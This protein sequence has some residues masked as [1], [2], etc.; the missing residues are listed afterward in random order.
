MQVIAIA[1]IHK[2]I[3]SCSAPAVLPTLVLGL[4]LSL[5]VSAQDGMEEMEEIEELIVTGSLIKG[6]PEDAPNPVTT[7]SRDDWFEQGSPTIV[8]LIKNLG[9]SSGVD[10]ETNQFTS[11]GL[12]GAANVNLRGLGPG[13]TLTLL[14]G[15]RL[16][17]SGS[18]VIQAGYQQFVDINLIPAIALGGVDFLREGASA[19][20]GSDAVAGVAN[21][22]T[23]GDLDG[24][25]VLINHRI[26]Q[27]SQGWTESGIA[28]GHQFDHGGHLLL[29]AGYNK[30]SELQIRDRP[31]ALRS[32]DDNPEGGWSGLG[33]PS[34]YV[35]VSGAGGGRTFL[36]PACVGF[37]GGIFGGTCRFQYTQY[38]NIIEN[39]ERWQAY[40]EYEYMFANDSK[41]TLSALYAQTNVPDWKTSPS[42]PPA[43]SFLSNI[44][45][46]NHPG[47]VQLVNDVNAGNYAV[48]GGQCSVEFTDGAGGP[49]SGNVWVDPNAAGNC[50]DAA[51]GMAG[52]EKVTQAGF[53]VVDGRVVALS[54]A[55][56][57]DGSVTTTQT[58]N[59]GNL[60]FIG[61]ILGYG[62]LE[63]AD[64]ERKRNQYLLTAD[65]DFSF[66]GVDAKIT[67]S[68]GRQQNKILGADVLG[69]RLTWAMGGLGG[70]ECSP[71]SDPTTNSAAVAGVGNCRYYNPFS[72]ALQRSGRGTAAYALQD[73]PNYE[74]TLANSQALLDWLFEPTPVTLTTELLSTHIVFAGNFF[75]NNDWAT[76]LAF[77]EDK[78]ASNPT[79]YNNANN[80]PCINEFERNLND[81]TGQPLGVYSFL[82]PATPYD[83]SETVAAAFG[84]IL[85][86]LL[87]ERLQLQTAVRFEEYSRSGNSVDPKVAARFDLTDALS[88]RASISTSFKAPQLIQSNLTNATSLAFVSA[89]GTFKAIDT[90][91]ASGGLQPESAVALN[92]GVVLDTDNLFLTADYWSLSLDDPI[93]TQDHNNIVQSVCPAAVCDNSHAMAAKLIMT[94]QAAGLDAQPLSEATQTVEL[95]AGSLNRVLVDVYNANE[96]ET[97]GIDLKFAWNWQ[98]LEAGVEYSRLI[99]YK[100][101][102]PNA[103]GVVSTTNHAGFLNES[104]AAVRPLPKDKYRLFASYDLPTGIG[105]FRLGVSLD[106][107]GD[108]T[109]ERSTITGNGKTVKKFQ[110]I[111]FNIT[112]TPNQGDTRF[113]IDIDNVG[114]TAPPLARLN[115][116]YDPYTH[117]PLGR[118]V[119]VGLVHK[120]TN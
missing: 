1:T 74:P 102:A 15:K 13:R 57:P 108:Y 100:L 18:S 41:L 14:N 77:R 101:T 51:L 114:D 91:T 31:N 110:K 112:Y 90:S 45:R 28:W 54:R 81:C 109:D 33:N 82:S 93:L 73:N 46:S 39:E 5:P 17:F 37:A 6:T 104:A 16:P 83:A 11:N 95:N 7:L 48:A 52:T 53:S 34:R 80:Y 71:N 47:F 36:D 78:V 62:A 70:P 118:T 72:N 56:A 24:V 35:N 65:Y 88:L 43:S 4:M 117:T 103:N 68:Y 49:T 58:P 99:D 64:G 38:F 21:F 61:R 106:G 85:W 116:N 22:R 119:K 92:F 59:G 60:L 27:D 120:F 26:V 3:R 40:A 67:T 76:G 107:I 20:Y 98:N 87:G 111:D 75:G 32:Y 2:L 84:E 44:I 97:S 69:Q 55:I 12:E 105:D 89:I 66:K 50:A 42:Y 10:G 113:F 9:I 30:R 19:T 94:S 63:P 86:S 79:G 29:A 25:E 115:I 23:R 8:E 96:L